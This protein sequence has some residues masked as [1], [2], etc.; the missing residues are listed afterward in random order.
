M[1]DAPSAPILPATRSGEGAAAPVVLLHGFGGDAR[2]FARLQDEIARRGPVIAYDLP[3][4]GRALDWPRIGGAGVAA[5][6]VA[7]SL[8]AQ[9]LPPVHL[10]GHSMGGA[11]AAILA[12][13]HPERVAS[14]TL[15][16]PGGFGREI[17]HRL[18]RRYAAAREAEALEPL[19][20]QFFGDA[21]SLPRLVVRQAAEARARPGVCETLVEIVDSLLDGSGQQ[22]LPLD[23]IAA[24][25]L[26]VR[27]VWGTADRVLPVGQTRGLPASFALH[28]IEGVGHMPHLE[29][30]ETVA[31][32]VAEQ[33]GR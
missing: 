20:E 9:A 8:E 21:F 13:K 18:L 16:A 5:R 28:L 14:L 23:E 26:P 15:L 32:I 24:L 2:G 22:V 33:A 1:Q 19:L 4:H 10:V 27:V 31:R 25:G 3:G 11:A 29:A 17:N 6:A 12:L 30:A 7:G